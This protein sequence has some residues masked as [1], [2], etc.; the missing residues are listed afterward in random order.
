MRQKRL[1]RTVITTKFILIKKSLRSRLLITSQTN[2]ESSTD[3]RS[4]MSGQTVDKTRR[5][6][7]IQIRVGTRIHQQITFNQR[8]WRLVEVDVKSRTMN[9]LLRCKSGTTSK[10]MKTSESN[11]RGNLSPSSE[12]CKPLQYRSTQ[13]Q[14]L[15][16]TSKEVLIQA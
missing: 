13:I 8:K 1:Q 16:P 7:R 5:D 2:A 9:G 12:K 15:N 11:V 10:D 4:S 3:S 14:S 6:T